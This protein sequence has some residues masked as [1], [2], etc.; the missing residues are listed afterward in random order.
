MKTR[1][2]IDE[3]REAAELYWELLNS[4]P[5]MRYSLQNLNSYLKAYQARQTNPKPDSPTTEPK[6]FKI[7]V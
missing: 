6:K 7:L 5:Q 2:L 4:K 3:R 1:N